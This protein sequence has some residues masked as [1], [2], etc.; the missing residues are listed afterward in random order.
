[1]HI[2]SVSNVQ[3][4]RVLNVKAILFLNPYYLPVTVLHIQ[5]INEC[6]GKCNKVNY[7]HFTNTKP[8]L[9]CQILSQYTFDQF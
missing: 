3:T 9:L 6:C 4:A 7:G 5:T 8:I 2:H 1:M